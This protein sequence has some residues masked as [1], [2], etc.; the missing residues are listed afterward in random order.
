MFKVRRPIVN[1]FCLQKSFDCLIFPTLVLMPTKANPITKEQ[2]CKRGTVGASGAGGIEMIPAVLGSFSLACAFGTT[3]LSLEEQV[4]AEY[5]HHPEGFLSVLGGSYGGDWTSCIAW[6]KALYSKE[7]PRASGLLF[8]AERG[9]RFCES[10]LPSLRSLVSS[11][12][13]LQTGW[14][15]RW[16]WKN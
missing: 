15:T 16:V 13:L 1:F 8:P 4:N 2:N 3:G 12:E 9:G 14:L 6:C 7:S 5:C 11:T 10:P